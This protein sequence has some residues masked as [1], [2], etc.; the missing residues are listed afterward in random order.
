MCASNGPTAAIASLTPPVEPGAFM[1]KAR[2]PSAVAMHAKSH[3]V[4]RHPERMIAAQA[5][6]EARL[7][8]ADEVVVNDGH[9]DHLDA[10]VAELDARYRALAAALL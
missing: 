6:R 10:R 8:I 5:T 4:S 2:L 1:T 9:P 7:A 3:S